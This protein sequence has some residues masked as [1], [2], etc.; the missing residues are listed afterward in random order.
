MTALLATSSGVQALTGGQHCTGVSAIASATGRQT[1]TDA[2]SH[3]S[4]CVNAIVGEQQGK[5]TC[6]SP[7]CAL[8]S[9]ADCAL[10]AVQL[11]SNFGFTKLGWMAVYV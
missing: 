11:V 1:L 7:K 3:Q 4:L 2:I 5:T 6:M 8:S 9:H 10:A